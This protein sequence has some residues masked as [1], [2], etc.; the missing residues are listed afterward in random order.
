MP[1]PTATPPIPINTNT[2]S[3]SADTGVKNSTR[4]TSII[5]L[6]ATVRMAPASSSQRRGLGLMPHD[7]DVVL[8]P[9]AHEVGH[10]RFLGE[11]L[12]V[13]ARDFSGEDDPVGSLLHR[14]M[15][16]CRDR[17]LP[18]GLHD[19]LGQS[20]RDFHETAPFLELHRGYPMTRMKREPSLLLGFASKSVGRLCR[21]LSL[22]MSYIS[23]QNIYGDRPSYGY[24][25]A[26]VK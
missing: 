11:L 17:V 23:G 24:E 20:I 4:H 13:V 12:V 14:H 9:A 6:L 10:H 16:K 15:T 18:Q 19:L 22:R 26:P 21:T 5:A 1:L 25:T 3:G 7:D 8:E 2:R